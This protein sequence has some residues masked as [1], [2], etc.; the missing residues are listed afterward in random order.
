MASPPPPPPPPPR[1]LLCGDVFGRL[2]QL[3]KRVSTVTKATGPFDALFCVGQFFP[4][5]S[6]DQLNELMDYIDG[7]SQIPI[8]TYFIGDYGFGAAKVLS[9]ARMENKG[10]KMDGLKICNNLFWLKGSGKFTLHEG[11]VVGEAQHEV[12]DL[13]CTDPVISELVAD[14]KPRYHVA[15]TKG[16]Y[17]AREPYLNNEAVHVTRFLGLAPVGNKDKQKFIHAISPTPASNMSGTEI[18][19]NPPNTTFSPYS[20]KEGGTHAKNVSKRPNSGVSDTQYWR[21]DVSQKRQRHGSGK[22][23][24]LCFKF[25][26]SGSCLQDE[27]CN[28]QHD[29]DGRE[30]FLRGVCFDFLNKGKCERGPECNFKH[31]LVDMAEE[32]SHGKQSSKKASRSKECWFCLS[33]PNVESHLILCI[34]ENF[35]CTLAK[36]PLV[37]DH[38][39]IVPIEHSSNVLD[40]EPE[41][42]KEVERLKK[43]LNMYFKSQGKEVVFFEWVSK[44]IGHTNI[45]AVPIPVPKASLVQGVFTLAAER[46]GFKFVESNSN[47][48]TSERRFF[49]KIQS[50]RKVSIFYVELPD[51]TLLS[52]SIEGNE[53]F[54]AQF[55]R[56]VL[57]G[58]LNVPNRADWRNCKLSKEEETKMTDAFKKRFENFDPFR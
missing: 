49:L 58:L 7:R 29:M 21:Y 31:S 32:I 46:V 48:D 55:G 1:I 22:N 5:S 20:H 33:S 17:Y 52:H 28:F 36:G 40:V 16:V 8:P 41:I 12:T 39:L 9:N 34:G 14:I 43:A 45:Q 25:V 37:E 53:K 26:S 42:E 2:N 30:Q 4:D 15:G 3:Y 38:A 50:S 13:T 57:A 23:E 56:E 24:K 10:F 44:H 35:Y 18:S 19:M 54:P 47:K 27:K 6:D 11:A 51:G